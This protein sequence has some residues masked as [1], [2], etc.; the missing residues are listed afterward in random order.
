M[1]GS[2]TDK[3]SHQCDDRQDRYDVILRREPVNSFFQEQS[4]LH[5]FYRLTNM[6]Y[7]SPPLVCVALGKRDVCMRV[8]IV[9]CLRQEKKNKY[10][11]L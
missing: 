3:L 2:G 6:H 4:I 7:S 10:C 8:C 1:L 5:D 11:E 9:L